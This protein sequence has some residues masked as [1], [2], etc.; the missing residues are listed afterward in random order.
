M[1]HDAAGTRRISTPDRAS[2]LSKAKGSFDGRRSEVEVRAIGESFPKPIKPRTTHNNQD[3]PAPSSL[4]YDS[5]IRSHQ[6]REWLNNDCRVCTNHA[7]SGLT[8]HFHSWLGYEVY[9]LG[10][11]DV[12]HLRPWR[13]NCLFVYQCHSVCNGTSLR[14][15]VRLN[16]SQGGERQRVYWRCNDGNPCFRQGKSVNE[17]EMHCVRRRRRT[18]SQRRVNTSSER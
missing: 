18:F 1:R 3:T 17:C 14:D 13:T 8:E 9:S 2:Q 7:T 4:E 16:Q 6:C 10:D 11:E 5:I 12:V 15:M